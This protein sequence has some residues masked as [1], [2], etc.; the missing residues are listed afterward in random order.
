M[1]STLLPCPFCDGPAQLR[2]FPRGADGRNDYAVGCRTC[3][4]ATRVM[5]EK[6]LVTS[7]WNRRTEMTPAVEAVFD[8]HR[9]INRAEQE[10][11]LIVNRLGVA[12]ERFT[13]RINKEEAVTDE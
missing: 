8:L 10:M 2:S 4:A 6:W 11:A 13:F 5:K 1:S 7:A 9:E 12:L 3:D